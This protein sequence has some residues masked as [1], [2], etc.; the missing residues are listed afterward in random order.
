T[1]HQPDDRLTPL[2]FAQ[3]Q[4]LLPNHQA[5]I[6]EWYVTP[7]KLIAFIVSSNGKLHGRKRNGVSAMHQRMIQKAVKRARFMALLPYVEANA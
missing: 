5:A 1:D 4:A 2:Q 7:E 6:I 3:M